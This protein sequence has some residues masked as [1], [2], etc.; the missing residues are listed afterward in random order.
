MTMFSTC[1]DIDNDNNYDDPDDD[2][3]R[4]GLTALASLKPSISSEPLLTC[5]QVRIVMRIMY[6]EMTM[7]I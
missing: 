3:Q 2:V 7:M 1:D 6:D 4:T 5:Q